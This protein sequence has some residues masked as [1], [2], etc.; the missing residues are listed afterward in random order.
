VKR[1][2]PDEWL[3]TE[4]GIVEAQ[5]LWVQTADSQTTLTPKTEVT[6]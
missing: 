3:L 6:S 5:E 2:G 4:S 1:L